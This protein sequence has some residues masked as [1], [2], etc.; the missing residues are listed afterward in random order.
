MNDELQGVMR[1]IQKLLAIANDDRANPNEAAAAAQQAEKIMRKYQI[2]H[3][4]AMRTDLGQKANFTNADCIAIMKRDVT[5]K[6]AHTPKKVPG[7]GG[8]LAFSVAKLNDCEIRYAFTPK[9]AV[10][11]FFGFA[12]DVQVAAWTFDY[13]VSQLIGSL[14]EYQKTATRSKQESESYRRGFTLSVCSM[15]DKEKAKKDQEMAAAATSRSLVVAKSQAIAEHFGDFTY[16]ST[17]S[18][19]NLLSDAYHAGREA[20]SKVQLR[21]G[22]S[23]NA[24]SAT[25]RLD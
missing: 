21:Q 23:S 24:S 10:I 15:L 11:R 7:W 12:A 2:D 4:D 16:R 14:R 22:V 6:G 5:G 1:R 25:L 19:A 17:S 20:G 3:A 9:G 18:S 13:L 8:W